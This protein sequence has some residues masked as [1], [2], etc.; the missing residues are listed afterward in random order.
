[1]KQCQKCGN[2]FISNSPSRI[3]DNCIK[4]SKPPLI[5]KKNNFLIILIIG[6]II[7]ILIIMFIPKQNNSTEIE[8]VPSLQTSKLLTSEFNSSVDSTNS[9]VS[10]ENSSSEIIIYPSVKKEIVFDTN[11]TAKIQFVKNEIDLSTVECKFDG[12]DVEKEFVRIL[13]IANSIK[14]I[15]ISNITFLV[16][17][18]TTFGVIYYKDGEMS[19][20]ENYPKCYLN[21]K[22]TDV[23]NHVSI[24]EINLIDTST[25]EL[26][27]EYQQITAPTN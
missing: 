13:T 24:D 12:G 3:C 1:M 10:S 18:N 21:I 22:N 26:F 17:S 4:E 8:N 19:F 2:S 16:F 7:L 20:D 15:G 25:K 11:N 5:N 6:I 27:E 9:S 23:S 14:S